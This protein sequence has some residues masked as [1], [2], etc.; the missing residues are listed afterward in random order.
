MVP[1]QERAADLAH[2]E[3]GL[4]ERNPVPPQRGCIYAAAGAGTH[5][6]P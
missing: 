4:F 3:R 1:R 5:A 2:E 6:D